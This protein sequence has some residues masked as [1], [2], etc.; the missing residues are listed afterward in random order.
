MVGLSHRAFIPLLSCW[1]DIKSLS[2]CLFPL[3]CQHFINKNIIVFTFN[4][5]RFRSITSSMTITSPTSL[6]LGG[7]VTSAK[8]SQA[9]LGLHLTYKPLSSNPRVSC[10][11][12]QRGH[13]RSRYF[14]ST[15]R[16][17]L[18]TKQWFPPPTNAPSIEFA[19]PAWPHPV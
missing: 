5:D 10:L 14:S 18:Q 3:S 7:R 11:L 19:P 12:V 17:Q 2:A 15:P 16:S 8:L 9:A 1:P 6:S 13:D 4:Y